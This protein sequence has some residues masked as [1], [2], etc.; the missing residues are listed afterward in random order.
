MTVA[1]GVALIAGLGNCGDEY[2]RNRHN[3]GFWFVDRLAAE[4]GAAFHA[5][6]KSGACCRI[7]VASRGVWLFKAKGYMNHSGQGLGEV[8]RYWKIAPENILV[9]YDE[10][11]FE[12]GR[13]RLRHGGGSAGHNGV[14]SVIAHIGAAFWR[15]RIGIHNPQSAT[16]GK[17]YVLGN[18]SADE[19]A[20]I[21]ARFD[22]AGDLLPQLVRGEFD[23][24]MTRLHTD[25]DAGGGRAG[26]G[27]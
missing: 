20:L 2:R 12:A 9:A 14:A 13:V 26:H 18:A 6:K 27:V 1:G 7:D 25:A 8:A 23:I 19:R 24:A 17:N 22:E 4:H 15:L 16:R 11:D 3:A 10:L 5:I 21:E